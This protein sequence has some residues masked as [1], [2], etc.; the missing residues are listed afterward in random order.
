MQ[1]AIKGHELKVFVGLTA[2]ITGAYTKEKHT[3]AEHFVK[4]GGVYTA[5]MTRLCTHLII[6][7][8]SEEKESMSVKEM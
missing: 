3:Y 2:S 7:K 8:H 6:V 1:V 5:E 4:H